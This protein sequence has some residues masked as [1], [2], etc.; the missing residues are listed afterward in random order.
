VTSRSEKPTPQVSAKPPTT[1]AS[2][3]VE[4][5]PS[6]RAIGED[7]WDA[8]G[9]LE[10]AVR[11]PFESFAWLASLEDAGCV[12]G[13]TGWAPAHLVLRSEAPSEAATP[14]PHG[15]QDEVLAAL[16]LYAKFHSEG[17]FVFDWSIA[18]ASE[19]AGVRYYPKLVSA[20]PFTPATG[21]RILVHPACTLSAEA[22]VSVFAQTLKKLTQED[23]SSAHVLFPGGSESDRW[24]A[25]GFLGR[26][27]MQYQFHNP[28]Y[29][30]FEEFLATLPSKKR[31]QLRRERKQPAY[32]GVTIATER[33]RHSQASIDAMFA[34][35]SNT[36]AQFYYGRQYLNRDFFELVC[37]RFADK[38]S[39]VFAR[40]EGK[41]IAGA[42]NIA[43]DGVLY[44]RYW[45]TNVSM[46]F[47]HFNVCFY[48][49]IDECIAERKKRFEP[50]AG[51]EHKR[52][53]GFVP[54][55]TRSAHFFAHQGLKAAV[56]DFYA[57]ERRAIHH[58]IAEYGSGKARASSE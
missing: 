27:G 45:G 34:F 35:Y 53:R 48:H 20:V 13:D 15:K 42:F 23:F 24:E 50:G 7:V 26:S 38:L 33:G 5:R 19:R 44:G 43:H 31:T 22:L 36:V 28:G 16:P 54:T 57:R 55:E 18:E 37:Q 52:V 1:E 58:E 56:K 6:I 4:I 3:H 29:Q 17:E 11:S 14:S 46:P 40:K 10:S 12:G 30:S 41:A 32:D 51:G 21:A 9:P 47:L 49:G 8:L 2:Y 39:W 25:S